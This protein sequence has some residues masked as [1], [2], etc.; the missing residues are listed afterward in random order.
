VKVGSTLGGDLAAQEGLHIVLL[1]IP[2]QRT[3]SLDAHCVEHRAKRHACRQRSGGRPFTLVTVL[4]RRGDGTSVQCT[5]VST[6][7]VWVSPV[8]QPPK[9]GVQCS[10][11]QARCLHD[12]PPRRPHLS[13]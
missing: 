13:G 11:Q 8:E 3:V 4:G 12:P 9:W 5:D 10:S 1:E 6:D 2:A 7:G